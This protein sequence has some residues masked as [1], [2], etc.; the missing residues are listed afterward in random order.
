M[1]SSLALLVIAALLPSR[2]AFAAEPAVQAP[3]ATGAT[4]TVVLVA[5]TP[6]PAPPEKMGREMNGHLFLPSHIIEDPFSYT[7]FAMFFGA[8]SGTALADTITLQPPANGPIFGPP[9]REYGYTNL[10][11]GVLM[12]VR[13]LEYLALRAGVQGNAYFGGGD[14]A[15]L[16][17]GSGARGT[18]LVGVKGSLPVGE[19]FRFA[20]TLDI[21]YGPVLGILVA[22]GLRDVVNS[23]R[24]PATGCTINVGEFLQ[25]SNTVTWVGGLSGAWAPL[26]YLGLMANMQFIWPTRTS[27]GAASVSQNGFTL[28]AMADFDAKPLLAWL[29]VGVNAFYS[30]TSPIGGNGVTTTQDYGFGFYY[31]GRRELALGL[32]LDWKKGRLESQQVSSATLAWIN[33]RY[34][35]N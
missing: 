30:I 11:I 5:A 9:Q 28:A 13:I 15:V 32:E 6:K 4:T 21:T 27:S 12:N 23:C 20:A 18:G 24:D 14:Q 31:T 2:I 19:K 16:V 3:D 8:G 33:F 7:A 17:I 26:P 22:D 25:K 1:R 10:G 29:P 35:W 34:Y